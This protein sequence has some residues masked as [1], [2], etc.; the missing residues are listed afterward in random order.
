[1]D[2]SSLP[3]MRGL[4]VYPGNEE[5]QALLYKLWDACHE[6][7][8][9]HTA[10]VVFGHRRNRH[11]WGAHHTRMYEVAERITEAQAELRAY[12]ERITK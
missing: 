4:T 9:L 12:D 5:R 3:Q 10:T 8:L 7:A 1:M 6:E 2:P 11:T